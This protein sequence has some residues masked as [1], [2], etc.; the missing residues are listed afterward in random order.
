[1]TST[2]DDALQ[3][4]QWIDSN[5][6]HDPGNL[7]LKV[8][9][10]LVLKE[11]ERSEDV[12]IEL[13][14][15]SELIPLSESLWTLYIANE[16]SLAS[17]PDDYEDIATI[18]VKSLRGYHSTSLAI[19][20]IEFFHSLPLSTVEPF[21]DELES[22]L[23]RHALDTAE[24]H[25]VLIKY[26]QLLIHFY[27]SNEIVQS[28]ISSLARS[29]CFH[30]PFE[31]HLEI[32]NYLKQ[33]P[34]GISPIDSIYDASLGLLGVC[35]PFEE[36]I[37]FYSKN[38]DLQNLEKELNNYINQL[39]DDFKSSHHKLSYKK[40]PKFVYLRVVFSIFDKHLEKFSLNLHYSLKFL[41]SLL[42]IYKS[43]PMESASEFDLNLFNFVMVLFSKVYPNN[44]DIFALIQT[45]ECFCYRDS[46]FVFENRINS[47]IN[48]VSTLKI[49][50]TAKEQAL[51]KANKAKKKQER[52]E[53]VLEITK[54][55]ES[56][57]LFTLSLTI[58]LKRIS[59]NSNSNSVFSALSPY[60]TSFSKVF[61][62]SGT[63]IACFLYSI[64]KDTKSDLAHKILLDFL[65]SFDTKIPSN[66][67]TLS[68]P[69]L[70][71]LLFLKTD[72][73]LLIFSRE[74]CK[75][76]GISLSGHRFV[77][78]VLAILN[79]SSLSEYFELLSSFSGLILKYFDE[80][81][82]LFPIHSA[83]KPSPVQFQQ[84]SALAGSKRSSQGAEP[85]EKQ[86]RTTKDTE[87]GEKKDEGRKETKDVNCTVF[88]HNLGRSVTEST[89]RDLFSSA[90]PVKSIRIPL[91]SK[92]ARGIAYVEFGDEKS[93][94]QAL[95]LD[96]SMLPGTNRRISVKPSIKERQSMESILFLS[97]LPTDISP[98]TLRQWITE[99][100][101]VTDGVD[102]VRVRRA[103]S[104][105][106]VAYVT[107]KTS[108]IASNIVEQS[109]IDETPL[110]GTVPC[111]DY[112]R[113]K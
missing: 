41:K 106:T 84:S 26:F 109:K 33:L 23:L 91:T 17:E 94:T 16:L 88:V 14:D 39:L 58:L 69:S 35:R 34:F 86:A 78:E 104:G 71:I 72:E 97:K 4:L 50:L 87:G 11:L 83:E 111:V 100:Y 59:L 110:E 46:E 64:F 43:I 90:G 49:Q 96:Q 37:S 89:V 93:A 92:G 21:L 22:C 112:A 76:A 99:T 57:F 20:A 45:I 19:S 98:A 31:H 95:L 38:N 80:Q 61:Q 55:E 102:D 28:K 36:K 24:G 60:L 5:L 15:L 32:T 108:E 3:R 51:A 10:I 79:S 68:L 65:K 85:M 63:A 113:P 56:L 25:S 1:M 27:Q 29:F 103:R 82:P 47:L 77:T 66:P 40:P 73:N 54:L 107:C 81:I 70:M 48:S 18:Y 62:T 13:E 6:E 53:L 12:S 75:R 8:D 7:N 67:T 52:Q 44:A 2:N 74:L 101:H 9:R 42:V 105:D 30:F